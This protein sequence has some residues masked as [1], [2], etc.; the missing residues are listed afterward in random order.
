[1]CGDP[2]PLVMPREE[3]PKARKPHKCCECGSDI[4]PGEKYQKITGLHEGSWVEFKTCYVCI[5][6]RAEAEADLGYQIGLTCL[7]EETGTKYEY[8]GG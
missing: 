1:M 4:D 2:E 7:Y 3:Y 8:A 6:V 5:N